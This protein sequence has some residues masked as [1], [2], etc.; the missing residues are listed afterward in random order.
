MTT[1]RIILPNSPDNF[2][3]QEMRSRLA[4]GE[5][6][7]IA[8]GGR[9]MLPMLNGESDIVTL[10]PLSA[11][12]ECVV[13]GIY[14]FFY[15]NHYVVHRLMRIDDDIYFFRG[16]NCRTYEQVR[17]QAVLGRL[18]QVR[19]ADGSIDVT[20]SE[21]WISRSRKVV[22]RRNV[23]NVF[24]NAF[25]HQNRWWESAVYFACLAALMWAPLNGIGIPLNN[26]V[27]GL[28]LDHLLHASVFLL[29]PFF[30]LDA[31]NK[32]RMLILFSAWLVGICTESVQYLLPWR[33][34]DVNDLIANFLGCFL[35]WLM[36]I[37][38]FRRCQK[39]T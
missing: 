28:R 38:Y 29:C 19:H 37:P 18:V 14:L 36:L 33:G 12:E 25:G 16:D 27:F 3:L 15:N 34:F 23:V 9:S 4:A 11:D 24:F 7:T 32:R 1:K 10:A 13:G 31:L 6:V 5:A 21:A 22:R 8:F 26:F 20:N 2:L 39:N 35:G 30:L 17:R